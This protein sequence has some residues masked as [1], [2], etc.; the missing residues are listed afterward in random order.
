MHKIDELQ[1]SLEQAS[2]DDQNQVYMV[3]SQLQVCCFDK[4]KEWYVGEKIP[5]ANPTPKSNDALYFYENECFFIEFKNGKIS[6]EV[7]FEIN[8]KIYDSLFILFDLKYMDP[9]G[10]MVD[11]ISYTRENMTYILVYNEENYVKFGN[12][13]QTAIGLD[14]QKER[15]ENN[16]GRISQSYYRDQLYKATRKLAKEEFILFGLDQFKGYLF[17]NVYTFTEEEF[18]EKFVEVKEQKK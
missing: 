14:R 9:K 5:Q 11:S 16:G 2:R 12:T 15:L 10:K 3:H 6:N 7:N 18:E 17:K 4:V 1:C 13:R 8:K